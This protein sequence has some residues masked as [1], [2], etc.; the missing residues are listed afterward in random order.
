MKRPSSGVAFSPSVKRVQS[1]RGSRKV[2]GRIESRAAAS[3]PTVTGE[4]REFLTQ[5]DTAFLATASADGQPYVQHRGGPR[6]FIRA[7]DDHT[8]GF[9]DLTGNRQYV[10]TGNLAENDRVC[11]LLMDYAHRRRVEDLGHRARGAGRRRAFGQAGAGPGARR[12]AHADHGV[13]VG[14]ELPAAHSAEGRRQ[15]GRAGARA[16]AREE[17]SGRRRIKEMH[18]H[19]L[20]IRF[21]CPVARQPLTA[22]Q[23]GSTVPPATAT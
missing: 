6:G 14:R 15:G 19:E 21:P 22:E 7:L 20:P 3:R 10:S 11:L 16:A 5:I 1:R 2:Y 23:G 8:I 12:A 9:A 13:R 17:G 4:L 18:H